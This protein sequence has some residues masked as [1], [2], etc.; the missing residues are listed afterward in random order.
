[1]ISEKKRIFISIREEG[2]DKKNDNPF[3]LKANKVWEKRMGVMA[4]AEIL[5]YCN[6]LMN[7]FHWIRTFLGGVQREKCC[8]AGVRTWY[9]TRIFTETLRY[10]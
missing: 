9:S 8:A 4:T 3:N 2:K 10:S 1:M 6:E 7:V 5:S